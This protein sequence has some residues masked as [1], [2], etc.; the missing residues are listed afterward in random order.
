MVDNLFKVEGDISFKDRCK[1]LDQLGQVIWFTGL[2]GSGKSTLAVNLEKELIKQG[3]AVYRLDGDNIRS[4]LNKDLG[5]SGEDRDENIRRVAEVARLFKEAG[6]ITLVSFISPYEEKREYAREVIG[7]EYF[8][9]VYVKADLETCA[10]RD[11]K[12]L[13]EKA[14]KGE[15]EDFTGISAPY[16]EPKNPDLVID[17]DNLSV[18]ESIE[19]LL[20][21]IKVGEDIDE[22]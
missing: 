2:S 22:A 3:K 15:I 12:G 19:K 17:T 21:I 10:A 4:G 8:S 16:E 6:I 1:N 18:E 5:F 7:D 20:E 14:K 13:Y 9:L 11:P